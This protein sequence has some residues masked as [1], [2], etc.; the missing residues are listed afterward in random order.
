MLAV[1]LHANNDRVGVIFICGLA[2]LALALASACGGEAP[3]RE[4]LDAIWEEYM[5]KGIF[6]IMSFD[7]GKPDIS[8]EKPPVSVDPK[9]EEVTYST[10]MTHPILVMRL[11]DGFFRNGGWVLRGGLLRRISDGTS[12]IELYGKEVIR[13]F[14]YFHFPFHRDVPQESGYEIFLLRRDPDGIAVVLRKWTIQ[15]KDVIQER[16]NYPKVKILF[17]Y[18]R[19]AHTATITITGLKRIFRERVELSTGR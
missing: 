12:T 13:R 4:P 7:E 3:P 17:D 18:E 9:A 8:I 16:R 14:P 2:L 5:Q 11:G 15:P 1:Y 6:V 10:L 19:A